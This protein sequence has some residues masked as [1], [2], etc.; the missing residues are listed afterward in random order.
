M[1]RFRLMMKSQS[2]RDSQAIQLAQQ[3]GGGWKLNALVRRKAEAL[4]GIEKFEVNHGKNKFLQKKVR[5]NSGV[6]FLC[7][8][9][10]LSDSDLK[11]VRAIPSN[12]SI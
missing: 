7:D 1:K 8:G 11:T 3:I 6:L 4:G 10:R 2:A 12:R 9:L 5:L